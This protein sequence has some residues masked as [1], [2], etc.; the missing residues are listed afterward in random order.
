MHY[1]RYTYFFLFLYLIHIVIV[2]LV[3]VVVEAYH[4]SLAVVLEASI[5]LIIKF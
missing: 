4:S 1:E 2:S 5:I 3:V